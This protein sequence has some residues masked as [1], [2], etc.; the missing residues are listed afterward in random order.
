MAAILAG[1]AR[2]RAIF[3]ATGV[4]VLACGGLLYWTWTLTP[5]PTRAT[6]ASSRPSVPVRIATAGRHDTPIYVSGLGAVQASFTIG[7][8]AQVDGIMQK[9]F[10]TEGQQVKAGDVLAKIDPRLFEAAVAQAQ[11]KRAQDVATLIAAEKDLTRS[12]TLVMR[13]AATEQLVDQQQA[14]VDQLK[15]SIEADEAAIETAKTQLDFSEIKA[16]SNG[17]VGVRLVDPGNLVHA[18]DTRPIVSLVLTQ[19]CAVLF[20]LPMQVLDDLRDAMARGSVEV[21]AYDQNDRRLLSTGRLLLIDNA[22]DQATATIR[23]KAM[24]DNT[25]DR[26]WPGEFVNARVLIETRRDAIVIPTTALQRGPRGLFVWVVTAESTVEPRPID[27]G[28]ASGD[29]TVINA[30]LADGERVVTDG[31]Y[32][33]QANARVTIVPSVTAAAR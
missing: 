17:R 31:Q 6:P 22:I 32:K 33:L 12:K 28:P 8:H 2:R 4:I 1:G 24:F 16:P 11:A 15:A 19:P 10:F 20:T 14:R 3:V 18:A 29:L 21:A 5:A 9:V 30:G 25:D 7:I 23:L 13:S 27:A 26:L